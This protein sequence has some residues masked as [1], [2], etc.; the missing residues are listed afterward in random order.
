MTKVTNR[1]FA[2]LLSF[3]MVITG[4]GWAGMSYSYAAKGDDTLN[5]KL[6]DGEGNPVSGIIMDL[7][8]HGDGGTDAAFDAASDADGLS[9]YEVEDDVLWYTEE[10]PDYYTIEAPADCDYTCD[11]VRVEFGADQDG[12]WVEKVGGAAYDPSTPVEITLSSK[13][14]PY[15]ANDFTYGEYEL[16]TASNQDNHSVYPE[17]NHDYM[18]PGTKWVVTG[19]S[20]SGAAKFKAGNTNLVIPAKD[21]EGRTVQG[22]GN[23]AFQ[24]GNSNKNPVIAESGKLVTGVTFPE[25]VM[26]TAN[27]ADINTNWA[28][29]MGK[30]GPLTEVGDFFIGQFAFGSNAITELVIPEGTL[31]IDYNAFQQN[32]SLKKVKFPSTLAVISK[33]AFAQCT[34]LET[35]EFPAETDIRLSVRNM[36][37]FQMKATAVELPKDTVQIQGG[38]SSA[39]RNNGGANTPT[40]ITIKGK[41]STAVQASDYQTIT[42]QSVCEEIEAKEATCE[43]PS[44]NHGYK[45]L[46]CGKVFSDENMTQESTAEVTPATGHDWEFTEL[47]KAPTADEEGTALYTCKNNPAHT[48]TEAVRFAGEVAS[49]ID[50]LPQEVTVDDKAAVEAAR[51]AYDALSEAEKAGLPETAALKLELAE[52]KL[53]AATSDSSSKTAEAK[54]DLA[55]AILDAVD[56]GVSAAKYTKATFG[57]YQTALNEAKEV[58]KKD[59]A[60]AAEY[61]TAADNLAAAKTALVEK[62]KNTIT[63]KPKTVKAK[64]KTLK[65]KAQSFAAKKAFAVSKAQGTVT[66]KKVSGNAKITVAKNGKVTVKKGLKKGTYKV[67]VK[68]TAAGNDN[69]LAGSKTVTIKVVVK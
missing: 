29:Y 45:C 40:A 30:H 14:A 26:T 57:D 23:Y 2:F 31:M 44:V 56:S 41:E 48:K 32:K 22:V 61:K 55:E 54:A 27:V 15:D 59:G 43:E 66:Y 64:V 28:Q 51:D 35:L 38:T 25:G 7:V 46:A 24:A 34:A 19:F 37:F 60:T 20:E 68:V 13:N 49:A 5:I 39:F 11:P 10:T 62:A 65:K 47:T 50:A 21:P 4:F 18:L 9:S 52:A 63:V 12:V 6:V 8:C 17:N 1:L 53:A 33:Q 36:A 3:A 42:Y 67:R 69:T 16:S 58:L